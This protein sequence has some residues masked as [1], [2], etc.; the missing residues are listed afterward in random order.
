MKITTTLAL[1][2]CAV[3]LSGCFDDDDDEVAAPP[4]ASNEVPASATA[5]TSAYTT[6]TGSLPASDTAAPV[7]VNNVQPPTSE[8]EPARP[9]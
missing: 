4:P 1:L 3:A 8:T 5:S 7:Q 9:I 2:S 6:Y